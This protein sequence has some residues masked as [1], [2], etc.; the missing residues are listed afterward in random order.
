MSNFAGHA[1]G[2]SIAAGVVGIVASYTN[3][4][5]VE[6]ANSLVLSGLVFLFSLFP[7]LDTASI[8]QRWFYRILFF[9]LC[10]LFFYKQFETATLLAIVFLVPILHKHR[11]LTHYFTFSLIFPWIVVFVINT[12]IFNND[13]ILNEI[14]SAFGIYIIAVYIGWWTHLLI[15]LKK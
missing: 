1:V 7:D 13:I 5:F 6:N 2:G 15:D 8:P 4:P 14:F 9:V 10:G 3:I 12:H 11:G